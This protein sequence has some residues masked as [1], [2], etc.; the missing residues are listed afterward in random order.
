M[1]PY[2]KSDRR[3]P[4]DSIQIVDR[5]IYLFGFI[6]VMFDPGSSGILYFTVGGHVLEEVTLNR[7]VPCS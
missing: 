6:S 3:T 4:S 1:L 2:V 5:V 7:P